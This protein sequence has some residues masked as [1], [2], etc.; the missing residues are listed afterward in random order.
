MVCAERR[1][2]RDT[3]SQADDLYDNCHREMDGSLCIKRS[4]ASR[5]PPNSV[6]GG[7]TKSALP[8][9][10][11]PIQF[12]EVRIAPIVPKRVLQSIRPYLISPIIYRKPPP[13]LNGRIDWMTIGQACG[14]EDNLTAELKK[15]LRLGLDA[16]IRWLRAP[17]A[18]EEV[19]PSAPRRFVFTLSPGFLGIND[20]ATTTHS[21]PSDRISR[22]RP[23][24][25][26]PAS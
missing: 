17:P 5:Q 26:G 19:R 23:Y 22:C 14:I 20:G 15:E 1:S 18:A 11:P 13:I 16:I 2:C 6:T 4:N 21:W 9:R 10:V 25:V 12:C 24:P 8:G 7:G 3:R